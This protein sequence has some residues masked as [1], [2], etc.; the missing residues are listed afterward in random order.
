MYPVLIVDDEPAIAELIELTLRDA[1]YTCVTAF[2]GGGAADLIESERFDLILLDVMLPGV[3]GFS[4]MEYIEPTGTPVIFI[5]AKDAVED[6]VRGLRAA[7]GGD[8]APFALMDDFGTTFYSVMPDTVSYGQRWRAVQAEENG[9]CCAAAGQRRFL[10][11][12]SPLA[13][14]RRALWLVNAYDITAL[15]SERDRQLR[16]FLLLECIA[17][18]LAGAAAAAVSILLTRPLRVLE[19]A[20]RRVAAGDYDVRCALATND[21]LAALG[22][23]F[24]AMT[25]AVRAQ[26]DALHAETE[27]QKRFVA[28][29]THE[30]KTPMTSIPGYADLLRSGVQPPERR[31]RAANHIYHEAKRLEQLGRPL[32]QLLGLEHGGVTPQPVQLASVLGE[33]RRSLPELSVR[34][35]A[36]CPR[37]AVVLAD[38]ALLCTLLRNLV[39]NAAAAKP[40]DGT[41]RLCC[42]RQDGG[43][44]IAVRDTGCGIAAEELEK[45]FEPFYR[46]DPSRARQN[47]GNGL[48]LTLCNEIVRARSGSWL[49]GPATPAVRGAPFCGK[50][51]G[52]TGATTKPTGQSTG[53]IWTDKA[54]SW[55]RCRKN[56]TTKI[57]FIHGMISYEDY[58]ASRPNYRPVEMPYGF[59]PE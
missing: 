26:I 27:R 3:D 54:V 2:S 34:F 35:T 43:W 32:L 53:W 14:Q 23:S 12:A 20:S 57:R 50:T 36:E 24:D 5:T 21:E 47:G 4:L 45:V 29:F 44:E 9:F 49:H 38:R 18:A 56:Q 30:L 41:V 19:T 39:L 25:S 7:Y 33:V 58:F 11:L 51:G 10:L 48:G 16:E 42:V 31:Q 59:R 37:D 1:G 55:P 13:G 40:R 6:R 17:L 15:F 28:S 46:V 52:C 8:L 22:E